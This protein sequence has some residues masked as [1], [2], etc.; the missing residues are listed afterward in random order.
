MIQQLA[1]RHQRAGLALAV[2]AI[3][4]APSVLAGQSVDSPSFRPQIAFG[5]QASTLGLGGDLAVGLGRRLA[6]RGAIHRGSIG[7]ESDLEDISY[8]ATA[9]ADAMS[10]SVDVHPFANRFYLTAGVVRQKSALRLLAQPGT[11]GF[12]VDG[13][14]YPADSVGTLRGVVALPEQGTLLGLGFDRTFHKSGRVSLGFRTGVV[15][16][17]DAKVSLVAD[18]PIT[19]GSQYDAQFAARLEEERAKAEREINEQ[20]LVHTLPMLEFTL[21]VRLF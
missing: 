14:S 12:E 5:L 11:D 1:R 18:G 3:L 4:A 7:T 15:L 9:Q 21:R 16:Q 6:L 17:G 13:Q 8:R 19:R 10:F 2:I 20:A